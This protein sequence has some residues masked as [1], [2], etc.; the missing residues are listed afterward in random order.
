ML[1][2]TNKFA[3]FGDGVGALS[4]PAS[5]IVTVWSLLKIMG[6]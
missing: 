4:R 2:R 6:D 5:G 1:I 3:S